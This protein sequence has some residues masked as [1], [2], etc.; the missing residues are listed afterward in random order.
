MIVRNIGKIFSRQTFSKL[1]I[2]L[3]IINICDNR[4]LYFIWLKYS[5]LYFYKINNVNLIID[6]NKQ[7][8]IKDMVPVQ[9]FL[10]LMK[11]NMKLLLQ[12]YRI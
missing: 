8:D 1:V 5:I 12:S 4:I 11:E 3:M 10:I 2:N 9:V 7:W 6:L